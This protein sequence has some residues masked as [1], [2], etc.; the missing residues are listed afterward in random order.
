MLRVASSST[1][2]NFRPRVRFYYDANCTRADV[3]SSVA[4]NARGY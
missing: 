2:N 1:S 3:I 4:T